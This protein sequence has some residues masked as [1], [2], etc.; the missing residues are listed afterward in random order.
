MAAL[1][2]ALFKNAARLSGLA[3]YLRRRSAFSR[4][5][6]RRRNDGVTRNAA[7][8]K[9]TQTGFVSPSS[10]Q[11]QSRSIV[12]RRFAWGRGA[13]AAA[14]WT[15]RGGDGAAAAA[16]WIV[17]G[18]RVAAAPRWRRGY[19]VVRRRPSRGTTRARLRPRTIHVAAAVAP[20]A[21]DRISSWRPRR[22]CETAAERGLR[23]RA[24]RER[25]DQRKNR[26]FVAGDERRPAR[27][28]HAAQRAA[29]RRSSVGL[30]DDEAP[31]SIR[32][33]HVPTVDP[34]RTGRVDAVRGRARGRRGGR[35][36]VFVPAGA[37]SRPY[38]HR[39]G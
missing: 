4:R 25:V 14:T 12:P 33:R 27:D 10:A 13:A 22:R 18:G 32:H 24:I 38:E 5:L 6:L 23:R 3:R 35:R 39:F 9:S 37:R 16:T 17:R 8:R 26:N 28:G 1:N 19:S 29:A 2:A 36:R 34:R 7:P 20:R 15:V 21:F 11:L 31:R 30:A